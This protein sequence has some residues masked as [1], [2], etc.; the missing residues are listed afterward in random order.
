MKAFE[1]LCTFLWFAYVAL[2]TV[3]YMAVD[4]FHWYQVPGALVL[5]LAGRLILKVVFYDRPAG[6]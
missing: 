5:I 3:V 2:I 1:Y 6:S 4:G